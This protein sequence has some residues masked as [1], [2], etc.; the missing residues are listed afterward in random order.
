MKTAVFKLSLLG[1][2]LC[3]GA[4]LAQQRVDFGKREFESNCASCHGMDGKGRGPIVELLRRSPPDLTQESKKNGGVFPMNRL[5]DVI[6]GSNV[7]AHGGRDMPIWGRDYRIKDAE[8]YM[9][10]PY[11]SA[12]LVRA[13][14]LAL[15]EYINRI[16]V[17]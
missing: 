9:D 8:Y 6:E 13:R 4:V 3:S 7:Q 5:Y 10:T 11:D 15:L 16:Q 14:I 2:A 12:G 17:K 1:L